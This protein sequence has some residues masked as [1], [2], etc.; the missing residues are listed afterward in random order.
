M[1]GSTIIKGSARPTLVKNAALSLTGSGGTAFGVFNTGHF[2]RL[3][4]LVQ[5]VGSATVRY[6][7]GANSGTYQVSSSFV[8]ASGG[9]SFDV[10]NYGHY[11]ELSLSQAA[12]QTGAVVLI[13]GESIR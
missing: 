8:V 7:M 3:A 5:V 9:A 10:L 13:Y 4:G 2:A 11:T 6:Q 12:S 1:A